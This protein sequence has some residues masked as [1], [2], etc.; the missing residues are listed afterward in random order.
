VAYTREDRVEVVCSGCQVNPEQTQ[1]LLL[2]SYVGRIV[3]EDDFDTDSNVAATLAAC[4][5]RVV[6]PLTSDGV[7]I[8]VILLGPKLSGEVYTANDDKFLEILSGEAAIG[9]KNAHLFDERNQRVRE[10]SALNTMSSA[11]GRDMQLDS[12]LDRALRQVMKVTKA[13]CGS[14]MLLDDASQ[15]LTIKA[16][17][18]LPI[19]VVSTTCTRL[20][21]GIAGWVAQHRKALVLVDAVESGFGNELA[22]EGIRS[23]LCV[24]LV[25]KGR[26]TGV[27]NISRRT[28][29]EAFSRENLKV[30]TAFAGQLAMA[31]E[32]ARLYEHL[33]STF[34]GTIGALAAAVDAKDP[35][36][37]GH[38]S[39]VTQYSLAIAHELC[40][41][42]AE[43][44]RLRIA[45]LLHDIGKI[46]IDSSILN[47]PGKL[48]ED[49]YAMIKSHP[50]IAANI[51]G[52]LEFL[53]DVVP[54]VQF[55]HEYFD[56]G[57]YPA[58]IA[59]DQIPRGAR[60]ISVAD[61]FN[62][63]TSDR[64]YRAALSHETAVDELRRNA[65]TQF[66]PEV[67]EAFLRVISRMAKLDLK[68]ESPRTGDFS[69]ETT[70]A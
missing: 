27:L 39:D 57:G 37:Y 43:T 18:G 58:G 30:V 15:T 52:S 55:H 29:N 35:Y 42:E 51:L 10:L 20:G 68:V 64:P 24:P 16:A 19:D 33:E 50:D 61:A 67:V 48:T 59:G 63:M 7:V 6:V 69:V 32:N 9:V 8:A 14:I 12:V 56:G 45:A 23:A 13:E 70:I 26:I 65:G 44:E 41:S 4:D 47:K 1:R 62:A 28:S 34:L 60:I 31:I 66:D 36:T 5:M 54:L 25:H 3:H 11:L 40:V 46:G 17:E 2:A 22:R 49:E 38:S 21:E 53:D